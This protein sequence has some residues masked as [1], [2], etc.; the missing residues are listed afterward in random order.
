MILESVSDLF[1][2][3]C[4]LCHGKFGLIKSVMSSTSV[5]VELV[6]IHVFTLSNRIEKNRTLFQ[7]TCRCTP[8]KS[9]R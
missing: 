1:P 6:F 7:A 9:P 4:Q 2:E 3:T 5:L 8:V